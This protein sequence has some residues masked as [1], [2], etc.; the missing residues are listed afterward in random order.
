VA[1]VSGVRPGPL[2]TVAASRE[3]SRRARQLIPSGC[4]TYAKA[5]DQFPEDL[6]VVIGRGAGCRVWDVDGNEFIELGM[7]LRTVTLGHA[8]EPVVAAVRAALELG[9]NYGR[10]AAIEVECAEMLRR[11]VPSAEMVKFCKNGSDA[12]DGAVR[13]ARAYTGRDLIAICGDQPFFSVG[14]WFIGSTAMPGGIPEWIRAHTLKFR[15]NDLASLEELFTR[16]PRAIACVVMEAGNA[17]EPAAAYLPAVAQLCREQGAVF[18]LDE[19]ITGFRWHKHGAQHVYGVRPDLS[20]FGKA[21]ANGFSVSALTGRRELMELGGHDTA[22]ERVFLLSTTHGAEVH[23]LAAALATMRFYDEHEVTGVLHERGRRLAE[24]IAAAARAAGVEQ[25]F[26]V[27]G[28]HCAM[29]Y[30]T[31]D[32]AGK[33]SQEFRTLFLQETLSRGLI[34]PSLVVSYSHSQADIDATAEIIGEALQTY[35]VAL[36]R[37]VDSLLRGRPVRPVMRPFA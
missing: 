30:V 1:H 5:D 15:Y 21:L 13:L 23:A 19:M 35:R 34:A 37:G 12:L 16:H 3:L 6:P 7:G 11:L 4:H 17:A 36:D 29:V 8:F 31:R 18:V 2:R 32:A 28:R 14:D 22:R 10:P 24:R 25:H 9:S 33:P 27:R 20:T 26:E